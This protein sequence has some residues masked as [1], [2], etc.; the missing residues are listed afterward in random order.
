MILALS[1]ASTWGLTIGSILALGLWV[2]LYL[3]AR[4]RC[5]KCGLKQPDEPAHG[6]RRCYRCDCKF[7]PITG[8]RL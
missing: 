4:P 1:H 3:H 5:P 2:I 8:N 7:D 6:W